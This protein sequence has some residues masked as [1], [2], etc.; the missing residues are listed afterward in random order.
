M[1][2]WRD[3]VTEVARWADGI[4]QV[5]EC[6]AGRFH[7]PEPRRRALAYREGYSARWNA[8]TVGNWQNRLATPPPTG[9]GVCFSTTVAD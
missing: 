5:H 8:R 6:I 4:E 9:C 1:V 3:E 2:A 7:R